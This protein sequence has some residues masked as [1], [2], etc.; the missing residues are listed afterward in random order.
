M[1]PKDCIR[2]RCDFGW[3]GNCDL[4]YRVDPLL[5]LAQNRGTMPIFN[6]LPRALKAAA[7]D[8][9]ICWLVLHD[10]TIISGTRVD[11]FPRDL[12]CLIASYIH[13]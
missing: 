3:I 12:R 9:H 4:C 5:E 11:W 6:I 13:G 1:I 10:Y 8:I 7:L 2:R